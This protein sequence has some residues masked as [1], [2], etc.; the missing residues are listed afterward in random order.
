MTDPSPIASAELQPHKLKL[1]VDSELVFSPGQ[2]VPAD[3]PAIH[4]MQETARQLGL[5]ID[6]QQSDPSRAKPT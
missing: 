3:S 1:G 6:M 5:D 2:A 4:V